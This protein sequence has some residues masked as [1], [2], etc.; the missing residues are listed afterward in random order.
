V[1]RL[2]LAKLA[3]HGLHF[4]LLC[5]YYPFFALSLQVQPTQPIAVT[6]NFLLLPR[7]LVN[8]NLL[9]PYMKSRRERVDTDSDRHDVPVDVE[10]APAPSG[11]LC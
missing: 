7:V 6:L 5:F 8:D 3:S 1:Q 11:W 9:L 2:V 10:F 4:S